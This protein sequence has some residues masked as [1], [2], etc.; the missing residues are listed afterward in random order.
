MFSCCFFFIVFRY[1]RRYIE[2]IPYKKC[3]TEYGNSTSCPSN[4]SAMQKASLITPNSVKRRHS[5]SAVDFNFFI[6]FSH[7]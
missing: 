4:S 3:H 2:L 1:F 7:V 5:A 6:T